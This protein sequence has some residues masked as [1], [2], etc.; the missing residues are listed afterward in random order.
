MSS[1]YIFK[2]K[3]VLKRKGNGTGTAHPHVPK[4]KLAEKI[5]SEAEE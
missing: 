3:G 2:R 1:T 5:T 4:D